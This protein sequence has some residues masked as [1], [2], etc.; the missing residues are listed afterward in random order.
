MTGALTVTV[1]GAGFVSGS[2]VRINGTSRET[3]FRNSSHLIAKLLPDDI[4][5]QG[6]LELTIFNPEPGGGVSTPIK[7]RIAEK[8]PEQ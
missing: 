3:E 7:L 1:K 2:A 4:A 6:E 5:E 8:V